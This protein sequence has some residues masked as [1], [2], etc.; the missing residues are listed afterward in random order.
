MEKRKQTSAEKTRIHKGF[1]GTSNVAS[2]EHIVCTPDKPR[3]RH[4]HMIGKPSMGMSTLVMNMI[5]D[6]IK[7]GH[8]VAVIDPY[9]DMVEE[10][11]DTC[12]PS[13]QNNQAAK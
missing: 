6:E 7:N 3:K 2:Q 10:L 13:S 11:L 5:M 12:P 4:V 8:G 1:I 9:G